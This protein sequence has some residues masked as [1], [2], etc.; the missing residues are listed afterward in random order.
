MVRESRNWLRYRL[1]Q[2][3]YAGRRHG[4]LPW[5]KAVLVRVGNFTLYRLAGL[6]TRDASNG[7]RLFSRRVMDE[8]VIVRPRL[9]LQHRAFGEM[10]PPWLAHRRNT[11]AVV[12]A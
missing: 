7:F 8:I 1:C 3:L 2:P 12:R 11:G 6:P 9:L 5:L 4:R 10:P